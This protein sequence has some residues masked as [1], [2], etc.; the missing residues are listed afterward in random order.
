M[1]SGCS[2]CCTQLL[3]LLRLFRIRPQRGSSLLEA[4]P[5]FRISADFREAREWLELMKHLTSARF[6]L[7]FLR[8]IFSF[9]FF[10]LVPFLSPFLCSLPFSVF[11]F[12]SFR[13][14][15]FFFFRSF[16]FCIFRFSALLSFHSFLFLLLSLFLSY[17]FF[18]QSGGQE[19]ECELDPS[20]TVPTVGS[21]VQHVLDSTLPTSSLACP[22]SMPA[23]NTVRSALRQ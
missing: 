19:A 22:R 23:S 3:C 10:L 4:T 9:S 11:F 7:S 14:F 20:L 1:C 15:S 17:F 12:F 18:V 13:V 8:F 2:S 16:P 21:V 6:P 5:P